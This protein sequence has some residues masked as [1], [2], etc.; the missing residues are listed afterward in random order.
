MSDQTKNYI[1]YVDDLK[2]AS[3]SIMYNQYDSAIYALVNAMDQGW[4]V[5]V[6]GNGGSAA[7]AEH[8]VC[9]LWKG[10]ATDC[11]TW[12]NVVNLG[13][14]QSLLTA[15]ANDIGYESVFSW[16]IKTCNAVNALVIAISSSG[17]SKNILNGLLEAKCK[18]YKTIA[19]VGFDG[20]ALKQGMFPRGSYTD[21]IIHVKSDNYGIVEDVHSM[22][23]HSMIQYIRK[24]RTKKQLDELKL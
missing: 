8:F 21:T 9:D 10:V 11:D 12:S 17:N 13:S 24:L 5:L 23:M 7:I 1:K 3:E 15:I 18:N 14:N 19:L 20:G 4:P 16:Q 2:K 22:I 6:M